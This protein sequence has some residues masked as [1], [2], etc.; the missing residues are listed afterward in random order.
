VSLWDAAALALILARCWVPTE[1]PELGGTLWIAVLWLIWGAAYCWRSWKEG[2]AWSVK[3][4]L[5]DVGVLLLMAGNI[6]SAGVVLAGQGDRRAA[7]NGL[8]EWTALGAAWIA[9]RSLAGRPR[10]RVLLGWNVYLAAVVLAGFGVWQHFVWYP[11]QARDLTQ[12]L[13]LCSRLDRGETF[14]EGDQR[15]Y[16]ALLA[17]TGSEVLAL[18]D[19]GHNQLLARAKFSVE[20]IGRFALANSFAA[21]LVVGLLA[22]MGRVAS[23]WREGFMNPVAIAGWLSLLLLAD[24][25]LLTK[26][27]SAVLGGALALSFVGLKWGMGGAARWRRLLRWGGIGLAVAGALGAGAWALRGLDRE[28]L[29]EAP[30]S[31]GYRLE[32][33]QG[34]W[35]VI[36]DQPLLGV[37]PGNFRQHYLE[38]KLAGSSEEI[39]DPH[40][41]FLDAWANGGLLGLVGLL[42]LCGAWGRGLLRPWRS[43]EPHPAPTHWGTARGLGLG[44]I[45]LVLAEEW[46]LQGFLDRALLALGLGWLAAEGLL[47]G[48]SGP[49]PLR[50]WGWQAAGL[51]LAV[52]LLF[53]GGLGMPAILQLWLV[54]AALSQNSAEEIAAPV[55]AGSPQRRWLVAAA[56]SLGLALA[57]LWSSLLPVLTTEALIEQG[58]HALLVARRSKAAE[59]AFQAAVRA[60][61][62][63]AE[64]RHELALVYH[65]RWQQSGG[66]DPALFEAAIHAEQAAV[67]RDPCAAKRRLFLIDWQLERFRQTHDPD[68]AHAAVEAAEA[69]LP[70]YPNYAPLRAQAA[71]SLQAAG[72]P[73]RE[74]AARALT[75]DDLNGE[76]GHMDKRLPG[77]LRRSLEEI[78]KA[79]E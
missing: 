59:Q 72:R 6:L 60:D 45:G 58:R 27:R 37:G 65:S 50:R 15:Q 68:A 9:I 17:R 19:A 8:W 16:D 25:L 73:A 79:G 63:A 55:A 71:L 36:L 20:P 29:S 24:C 76:R 47:G 11:Q 10:T 39:L 38:H 74:E 2:A 21:L 54:A 32:Y 69:A 28:V 4:H 56:G 26:S 30:K 34:T 1:A 53:A 49:R 33:W 57:C 70:L 62:L 18:D 48:G 40:N 51:A 5:A 12:L 52:N 35:G 22:G 23:L 44:A 31:L 3:C 77:E 41:M 61:S 75:L 7:L 67:D 14:T 64:P 13:A 43:E 78:V 66:S 42:L 46:L